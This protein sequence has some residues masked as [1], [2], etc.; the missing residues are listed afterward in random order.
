[1]LEAREVR[2]QVGLPVQVHVERADVEERQI[3]EL[4]RGKIDV[5][6]ETAA[7]RVLRGLV[8][9][10][11]EVPQLSHIADSGT[12]LRIRTNAD[13]RRLDF[14]TRKEDLRRQASQDLDVDKVY[15]WIKAAR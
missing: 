8:Q 12:F 10:A 5:S 15:R 11:Q 13:D 2:A 6:E 3:E 7:R 1:M 4:G 14:R 9:V